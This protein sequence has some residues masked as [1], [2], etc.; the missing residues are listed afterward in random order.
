MDH[1]YIGNSYNRNFRVNTFPGSTAFI[2]FSAKP[3]IQK[4]LLALQTYHL[5][6]LNP[7]S[8]NSYTFLSTKFIH[9]SFSDL[10]ARV[11]CLLKL[12]Q[13]FY[14]NVF[15]LFLSWS[16]YYDRRLRNHASRLVHSG[17]RANINFNIS[18]IYVSFSS[19]YFVCSRLSQTFTENH[20]LAQDKTVTHN[21]SKLLMDRSYFNF[22]G[23]E[24]F[25]SQIW[26][27][28]I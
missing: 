18:L 12:P 10:F 2:S 11:Y 21:H 17:G 9:F 13:Q 16:A 22:K 4:R 26:N 20:I 3:L 5:S 14:W 19:Y 7:S 1:E 25:F 8:N 28:F 27:D 6:T 23:L 24:K 15:E